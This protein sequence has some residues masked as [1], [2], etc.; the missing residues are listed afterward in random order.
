MKQLFEG[1][2]GFTIVFDHEGQPACAITGSQEIA[3][4]MKT[5]ERNLSKDFS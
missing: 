4:A 1:A 2:K 5:I 3:C